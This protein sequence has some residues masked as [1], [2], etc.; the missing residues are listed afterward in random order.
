MPS[1]RPISG[2]SVFLQKTD[3][4]DA[5]IKVFQF[6]ALTVAFFAIQA[7]QSDIATRATTLFLVSKNARRLLRMFR[8]IL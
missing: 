3:G 1:K 7:S 8:G 2:M 5:I 4:R 6:A